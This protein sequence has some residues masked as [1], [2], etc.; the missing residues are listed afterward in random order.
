[1]TTEVLADPRAERTRLLVKARDIAATAEAAQ[2]DLTADEFK[3]IEDCI[4]DA[5]AIGDGI[6]ERAAQRAAVNE[7][8]E[9]LKAEEAGELNAKALEDTRR[10]LEGKA[11]SLG[12]AFVKSD[13][14]DGLLGRYQGREIPETAKGIHTDPMPVKGGLKA[15]I[16]SGGTS[17]TNADALVRDQWLG[18]VP[19]LPYIQPMLRQLITVGTT[20]TDRIE[21]AQINPFGTAGSVNAAKTVKEATSAA[22]PTAPGTAGP[23][24]DPAGAGRKPE[25]AI[26]FRKASADVMTIAHWM[27]VTKRALSDAAQIRTIIDQFLRRGLETELER[28]IL[29]GN[30]ASP[31]GD[32]EWNGILNT[33]GTQAQAFSTSLP[34]TIRKAITKVTVIGGN[35]DAVLL[36]PEED[37]ALDL[38]RDSNNR[39]Y[40]NGPFGSGPN[41]VWGR[42]RIV[43]PGLSGSNKFIL[44]DFSTCVLWDREQA[45]ITVTDSHAD[46]FT[47]NLLAIL[48]EA[49]AAF[50]IF[51]PSLLV[52]GATAV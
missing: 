21:Y 37:E 29:K 25:S 31:V 7:V 42:P 2:R 30:A 17:G 28:M 5:K 4:R 35:V 45:G 20:N 48:A 19:G 40:G 16:A 18:I 9:L 15:L 27:P 44:G 6:R 13:Q 14:Y 41:T 3:A 36:S 51:N 23:L 39:Y 47:R 50:G 52:V 49:R 1:M 34:E 12:S 8:G 24:V 38:L 32:E 33:T 43:V 46:F 11:M 10:G 26:T 22:A